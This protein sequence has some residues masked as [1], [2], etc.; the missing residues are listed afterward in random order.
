MFAFFLCFV[1][2]F[3]FYYQRAKQGARVHLRRV[4]GLDAIDEAIGRC[5]EMGRPVHYTFGIGELDSA[6][7]ASFDVLSHVARQCALMGTD[8]IVTN[9]RP[10]VHPMTEEIVRAAYMQEGKVDAYKPDNVRYLSSEQTAYA[11]AIYGIFMREKPAANM[12]IG[13]FFG[14]SLMIAEVGNQAGA[15]QIGGTG[16][17]SQIAFF[18]ATC[19]Y[20]LIGDELFAAGAYISRKPFQMGSIFAQ[21]FGKWAAIILILLGT[22]AGSFGSKMITNLL[23]N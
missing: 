3:I 19:D 13:Q 23:S 4:A 8:M 18:V 5:T 22:V 21:D 10:E 15:I 14:E 12:M 1:G 7:L 2:A 9:A 11:A 16:R 20:T 6:I 17:S